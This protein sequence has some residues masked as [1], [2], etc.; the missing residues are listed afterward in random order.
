[1]RSRL[2]ASGGTAGSDV[3]VLV[4]DAADPAALSDV[5]RRARVVLTTGGY[6]WN[7]QMVRDFH[8]PGLQFTAVG[9]PS[10]TGDGLKM[11]MDLGAAICN[12]GTSI[13]WFEFAFAEASREMGTGI[14]N[15]QWST[16]GGFG[17]GRNIEPHPSKIF[18][19]MD[20]NR[21]MN[22]VKLLTH[23]KSIGL[24]FL[25]YEGWMMGDVASRKDYTNLPLFLVCDSECI[26]SAPLGAV[27]DD[28]EWTHA[29]V[30]GV[31]QWS[32]DNKAEIEKGWLIEADT[33]E[34][35][36]AKM[37]AKSYVTGESKTVDAEAL[38]KTIEAYNAACAAGVDNECKRPSDTLAPIV[39]PPF[40]AAEMMPCIVYTIGGLKSDDNNQV[41]NWKDEPIA[42]LYCA[43][44]IGQM[45][46]LVPT[47]ASTQMAH[48]IVAA[49]HIVGLDPWDAE[50]AE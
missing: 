33:I 48:A 42:R 28:D 11:A 8:L 49:E 15:R 20:G 24:E 10:V 34:E 43:G 12:M 2:A 47:T 14:A 23:D 25:D 40:Y 44:N 26:K 39:T 30:A 3:E 37:T 5:V 13:D 16:F 29:R 45:V 36:A 18:V 50:A 38:K 32:D 1:V 41:L 9:H 7:E 19:N 6:D 27:L 21:F 22:E 17:G 4:A 31:Y 46:D 35:L